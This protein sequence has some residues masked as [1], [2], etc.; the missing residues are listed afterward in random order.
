[1][2]HLAVIL[3]GNGRWAVNRG[4]DR[5]QGYRYGAEALV[6]LLEDFMSLPILV[7]TVYAFSTENNSR[8]NDEVSN[9][10]SVIASFLLKNVFP[11]CLKN[12]VALRFIGDID[13]LPE[14]VKDIVKKT[15][16]KNGIK[17]FVV[18]LNYGGINEVCRAVNKFF[19]RKRSKITEKDI[20]LSLDTGTLPPPDAVIRYGGYKRM[21]NFLPLQSV[22]SEL[23]FI[24]K[25]WPDYERND[26]VNV[27][28]DFLK[29][30]RNFG[31]NNA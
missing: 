17:T 11:F 13:N 10:Y 8:N 25:L 7:L 14:K 26:I 31:G 20:L 18:A 9:I 2:E 27:L 5:S 3:D 29:I 12:N 23:F 30:K 21:S 15:E 28:N 19:E 6:R 4:R 1:M 16:I 22:Y 24:D